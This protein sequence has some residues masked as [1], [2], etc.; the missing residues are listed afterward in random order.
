MFVT[1]DLRKHTEELVSTAR[2]APSLHNAQPWAFRVNAR[3]V[4]V[5]VDRSRAVAVVD[6]DDRQMLIGVGASIFAVRLAVSALGSEPTVSLMPGDER[7][8]LAAVVSLGPD[9]LPS[10]AE[11]RLLQ[12][13]PLRR[14]MRSRLDPNVPPRTRSVLA[15]EAEL[16]GAQLRW[17]TDRPERGVLSRLVTAAER[18]EQ[19]DPKFR[20]ELA[21][22]VG[23]EAPMYGTGLP[24]AVLGV[25][26]KAGHEADFPM[27]DFA[28]GR[29]R[30]SS[31]PGRPERDPVIAVLFT[32]G[33]RPV[34][35]LRCGQ[36]LMRMLLWASVEGLAASYLNQ[37][38]ELPDLRTR[39][40]DDLGLP[41]F[42]QL[43]L[44]FGRPVAGLPLPT[45]RRPVAEL[46]RR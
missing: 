28:G 25:S 10:M 17:I 36:A 37:P 23:G 32:S 22:W 38:L 15:G 41:G 19:A 34:D 31:S 20:R 2:L 33:D 40:R 5:Y 16:E 7:G 12:H 3:S 29:R 27:R 9:H 6:P 44:R 13:V 35:W 14:T 1:L 45:P 39:V 30:L 18:R 46:L 24:E 4:E 43:I 21:R 42:A 26:A 8:D 11:T